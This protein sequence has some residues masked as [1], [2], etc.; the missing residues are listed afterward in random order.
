ML[1][2]VDGTA[3]LGDFG[4]AALAAGTSCAGESE[5]A[6]PYAAPELLMGACCTEKVRG[7][8]K[9]VRCLL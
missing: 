4:L 7:E 9:P 6:F 2:A 5:V 3:K 8:R 1:L